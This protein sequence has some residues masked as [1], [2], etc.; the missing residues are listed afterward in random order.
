MALDMFMTANEEWLVASNEDMYLLSKRTAEANSK[1]INT[2]AAIAE[3]ESVI[4]AN[5]IT[6]QYINS[7]A[8]D[9]LN[10]IDWFRG[11]IVEEMQAIRSHPL[12][13]ISN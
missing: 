12:N 6:F 13:S 10:H 4:S 7:E 8:S 5:S 3:I 11:F 1:G 9:H 2:D